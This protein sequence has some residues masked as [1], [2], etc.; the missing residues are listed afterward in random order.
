MTN[1][2]KNEIQK[3]VVNS[4]PKKGNY[5]LLLAP[6]VGK[7]KIAIDIIKRDK[8]KSILWVTPSTKLAKEDI[9]SEFSKWK[10]EKYLPLL[11]SITWRSLHKYQ[12]HYDLIILDE[13]Q[14]ITVKNSKN[15]VTGKLTGRIISMTGTPT[16]HMIKILLYQRLGLKV[17]YNISI[18]SAVETG[19]LSNYTLKVVTIDLDDRVNM[20]V[21]N[22]KT[23]LFWRTSEKKRY[24]SIHQATEKA[25]KEGRKNAKFLSIARMNY[26]RESPS[27]F[28]V[29]KYLLENLKGRKIAFASNIQQAENLS[30]NTYHSK[31]SDEKYKLFQEESINELVMVNSGG[32][33]HTFKKIDHL[34]L[35]QAD[36]NK[37]GTTS[38]KLSRTLL[39]Q[40]DY[41][42][43]IWIVCLKNTKDEDWVK[44][45][46]SDFDENK[47]EYINFKEI[48]YD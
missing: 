17:A 21:K 5:R 36:S 32:I 35:V 20:L 14:S 27:K 12:G 13:E 46:L 42:A 44:S 26:I 24:E 48:Q 9:P 30:K 41:E 11:T 7:T 34:I 45:T 16:E 19:L 39:E 40:G 6:R 22:S 43:A 33:G 8:P 28:T 25:I 1:K 37:N 18:N 10:A 15:L 31:T 38:Q 4:V 29:A 3:K 47:I 23:N 2:E